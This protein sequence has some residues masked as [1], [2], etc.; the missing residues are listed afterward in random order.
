M[1]RK[2]YLINPPSPFLFDD[3]SNIPL[4][5]MFVHSYLKQHDIDVTIIDLAG[6]PEDK[7]EIP[8]DGELYGVSASTPQFPAAQKIGTMLRRPGRLVVLGGVHGTCK[9]RE[10]LPSFDIVVKGEGELAMLALALGHKPE[11]IMGT[12]YNNG[13]EVLDNGQPLTTKNIDRF[14]YPV[15]DAIDINSYR[16]GVYTT[17]DGDS[18][19]GIPIITARGCP[20]NCAFCCSPELYGRKVRFHSATYLDEWLAYLNVYGYRHFYIVDDTVLLSLN[21]L[22]LLCRTLDERADG[23]RCCIR[24]D[25]ATKQKLSMMAAAG[26]RQVDIGVETGSQRL[27]D[28]V[29]KGETVQDNAKAIRLAH[30]VGIKVKAC[31]IVGLPG[32]TQKDVDLTK[33]FIRKQKPD[34]VTL[35]TFIPFPGCAIEK[36]PKS[37]GFEID[38]ATTWGQYFCCGAQPAK[39]VQIPAAREQTEDFRQ[40]LLEVIGENTTLNALKKRKQ[41]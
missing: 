10:S 19:S 34:S 26:C 33:K 23:W 17:S 1:S 3:K 22:S 11:H 24:G 31:I 12:L 32:E 35:C 39:G 4:G 41:G 13:D 7:W 18:V 37:Y 21:R 25:A 15:L 20:H 8:D 28:H 9:P 27:L 5:L 14:P 29:G 2:T 6:V 16:C 38:P 40:Q 30:S 36:D